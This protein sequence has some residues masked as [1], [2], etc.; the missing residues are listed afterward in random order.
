MRQ[1]NVII[2]AGMEAV[3]VETSVV[4]AHRIWALKQ[5]QLDTNVDAVQQANLVPDSAT[6]GIAFA[7][8]VWSRLGS[9]TFVIALVLGQKCLN[10]AIISEACRL[11]I[12]TN[13]AVPAGWKGK[14]PKG[15]FGTAGVN[16]PMAA[17]WREIVGPALQKHHNWFR[18][19][20]ICP[21]PDALWVAVM[22]SPPLERAARS[23]LG[24]FGFLLA[25]VFFGVPW[26]RC[27][28]NRAVTVCCPSAWEVARLCCLAW[29]RVAVG[30]CHSKYPPCPEILRVE[31]ALALFNL[32]GT[33]YPE[34]IQGYLSLTGRRIP[35][36]IRANCVLLTPDFI[37]RWRCI[38][39]RNT[40]WRTQVGAAPVRFRQL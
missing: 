20:R 35:A 16:N 36:E 11:V 1:L 12:R 7:Q 30:V 10:V 25:S 13:Y 19:S 38:S 8:Q 39:K 34:T 27:A 31:G 21:T 29:P 24:R 6:L 18:D 26:K 9:A 33:A 5:I 28:A 37:E 23:Q 15:G 2:V 32:P 14:A 40:G 22:V 17:A 3:V 4:T